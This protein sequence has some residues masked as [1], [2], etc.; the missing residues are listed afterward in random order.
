[1]YIEREIHINVIVYMY[2]RCIYIY[3]YDIYIY[4]ER[5]RYCKK[6]SGLA[7]FQMLAPSSCSVMNTSA[8]DALS[9]DANQSK[10]IYDECKGLLRNLKHNTKITTFSL[11]NPIV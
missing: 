11:E 3:I 5:E 4:I 1:M 7:R 2:F 10:R 6:P 8:G 9:G